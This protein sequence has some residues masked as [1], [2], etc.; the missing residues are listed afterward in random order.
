MA[1]GQLSAATAA[2]FADDEDLRRRV[3]IPYKPGCRYLKSAV[4]TLGGTA[5]DG[6]T[7]KIRCEF[8]IPESCYIDDTGHFNAVEFNI[9]YNQMLYYI[10]AKAVQEQ[11]LEPFA[12][13][14]MDEYWER[15][16]GDMFIIDYLHS[17]FRRRMRGRRFSGELELL[18][19]AEWDGIQEGPW[20]L[21][22]TACRFW[23]EAGGRCHGKVRMALLTPGR[24]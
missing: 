7:A 1:S 12:S 4:M 17:S 9:C 19:A 5:D 16:L 14:T 22:E 13:W 24:G 6:P 15:Q 18:G 10:V 21:V 3:L 20:I 11:A 8:E 23:E 2:E